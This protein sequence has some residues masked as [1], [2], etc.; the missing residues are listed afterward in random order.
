[1]QYVNTGGIN[2]DELEF[3]SLNLNN[4][5]INRITNNT[6][7]TYSKTHTFTGHGAIMWRGLFFE[8]LEDMMAQTIEDLQSLI[9]PATHSADMIT[10]SAD[11]LWMTPDEKTKAISIEANANNY[12][13]PLT[14]TLDIISSSATR[15]IFTSALNDKLT[16]IEPLANKYIHPAS[17]ALT[18]FDN[19]LDVEGKLIAPLPTYTYLGDRHFIPFELDINLGAVDVIVNN[20]YGIDMVSYLGGGTDVE[21]PVIHRLGFNDYTRNGI[22]FTFDYGHAAHPSRMVTSLNTSA[23]IMNDYNGTIISKEGLRVTNDSVTDLSTYANTLSATLGFKTNSSFLT[24]STTARLNSEAVNHI[25]KRTL[26]RK[27]DDESIEGN[28]LFLLAN[29]TH[30]YISGIGPFK[31]KTADTSTSVQD[32]PRVGT[33]TADFVGKYL[34]SSVPVGGGWFTHIFIDYATYNTY[35]SFRIQFWRKTPDYQDAYFQIGIPITSYFF[36]LPQQKVTSINVA[37]YIVLPSDDLKPF[38]YHAVCPEYLVSLTV[39]DET[40][41]KSWIKIYRIN[42]VNKTISL[43]QT[44]SFN[45]TV[46]NTALTHIRSPYFVPGGF[47]YSNLLAVYVNKYIYIYS[48]Y[49]RT[50]NTLVLRHTI[51]ANL[52][53]VVGELDLLQSIFINPDTLLLKSSEYVFLLKILQSPVSLFDD[54]IKTD[55]QSG[56][57]FFTDKYIQSGFAG[58]TIPQQGHNIQLGLPWSNDV[59]E[60]YTLRPVFFVYSLNTSRKTIV[61]V[62]VVQ[63]DLRFQRIVPDT[64]T[65]PVISPTVWI[66][67]LSA[68]PQKLYISIYNSIVEYDFVGREIRIN[69]SMGFALWIYRIWT[70][71]ATTYPN[72]VGKL[73]IA[74]FCFSLGQYI[75]AYSQFIMMCDG[76]QYT[77]N[78]NTIP[79][80]S[81]SGQYGINQPYSVSGGHTVDNL[82]YVNVTDDKDANSIHGRTYVYFGFFGD[83]Y[84]VVKN[85][86]NFTVRGIQGKTCIFTALSND[87]IDIGFRPNIILVQPKYTNGCMKIVS[88]NLGYDKCLNWASGALET[89]P[90]FTVDETTLIFPDGMVDMVVIAIGMDAYE[91]MSD[92]SVAASG[93][94]PLFTAI[95]NGFNNI[96]DDDKIFVKTENTTPLQYDFGDGETTQYLAINKFGDIAYN[97]KDGLLDYTWNKPDDMLFHDTNDFQPSYPNGPSHLPLVKIATTDGTISDIVKLA[98]NTSYATPWEL[99]NANSSVVFDNRY[100]TENVYIEA[101]YKDSLTDTNIVLFGNTSIE[102]D[103]EFITVSSILNQ[104]IIPGYMSAYVRLIIKRLF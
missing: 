77:V 62:C 18:E 7:N 14:H 5:K 67:Y 73:P 101:Q 6:I 95:H 16:N 63:T 43:F 37:P 69:T 97:N 20:V 49:M 45:Y 1:M 75:S 88:Q 80:N 44:L 21:I 36:N 68:S 28:R 60:T 98:T 92:I 96:G 52:Y 30:Y 2:I 65:F 47:K 50:N 9:H 27:R 83:D 13:H 93:A 61:D 64:N 25:F 54:F 15:K 66:T 32:I 76:Y 4:R 82:Y 71:A 74:V 85:N 100:M 35:G 11:K 53:N 94:N 84:T 58:N 99:L 19:L 17:H 55:V 22:F 104:E 12:E 24:G 23:V 29:G 39:C 102:F 41:A 81:Q 79:M 26:L 103:H 78:R 56:N 46:Y 33:N 72:K 42:L 8:L 38:D 91:S 40:A 34:Y 57:P 89:T 90:L 87:V 48:R 86:S 31:L 70:T 3:D 59:P 51:A 10:E